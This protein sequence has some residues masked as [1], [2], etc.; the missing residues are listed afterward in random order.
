MRTPLRSIAPR[1]LALAAALSVAIPGGPVRAAEPVIRV[2]SGVAEDG[3]ATAQWL[4]MLRRRLADPPYDSVSRIRRS[5]TEH[6]IAWADSIRSRVPQWETML[7]SL[8]AVFEPVRPPRRVTVVLGN[9]G[10]SDA[11]THDPVTIGFD[12]A[13]LVAEYGEPTGERIDRLFRHEYVHLLQKARWAAQPYDTSTALRYALAEMWAEGL[14]NYY[15]MSE[16][17]RAREGAHAPAAATA[18]AMLEPRLVARVA[19][20]ACAPSDRAPALTA[21]LSWGPFDQK[22]GALVPALWLE[23]E[24]SRSPDAL[25]AFVRRG[26]DGVWD[27]AGRH[28]SADLMAVMSEA[29]LAAERCAGG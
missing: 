26:P 22:W 3:A 4:A 2:V 19:A 10:A 5:L 9:R 27:L 24:A 14:G 15:S 11:F 8:I 18:L 17:W 12:L 23:Q 28:L 21:D 7:P 1:S 29:R 20:L 16:R 25:R 6:E 13:A